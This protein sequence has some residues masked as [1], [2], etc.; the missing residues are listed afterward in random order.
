MEHLVVI[1]LLG[2]SGFFLYRLFRIDSS[3]K[4]IARLIREYR[5]GNISAMLFLKG[6]GLTAELARQVA[7]AL[8]QNQ[9]Q[10]EELQEQTRMLE[11]TLRGMADGVLVVDKSGTVL[12]ANQTLKRL[13]ALTSNPEGKKMLEIVRDYRLIEL[14][15]KALTTWQVLSDEIEI[16]THD[17]NTFI[18][19]TAVPMYSASAVTGIVFTIQ[20]ITR[21]K[22]LEQIRKDFVANVSHEI[23]TPLTAIRAGAETL[24]D[25]AIEDRQFASKFLLMIKNHSERLNALVDDLLTLSRMELGDM[26]LEKTH[27]NLIDAIDTTIETLR[28]RAEAKGLYIRKDFDCDRVMIEGDKNKVIQILLNLTDNAIKFTEKGGVSLGIDDSS[29]ALAFYVQDTGI[30]IP[31][32]HL[33]R[34]GERFYRV[35]RAR[36]RE[37]GGTGLGLAIVKHIVQLHGWS[38]HI[39]SVPNSGTTITIKTA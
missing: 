33:D 23:K 17:K 24:L 16:T 38:M 27:F 18:M 14:F 36:S 7:K 20:D 29:G 5:S 39:K 19:A 22:K 28:E 35:D 12:L 1:V 8:E 32:E 31:K 21:L 13:L 4:E 11:T 26:P 34:I 6:D 3:I 15:Q 9:R 2:L 10:I 25:S 30:G 37:L